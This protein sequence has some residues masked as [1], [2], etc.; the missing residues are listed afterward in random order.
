MRQ[1]VNYVVGRRN[2]DVTVKFELGCQGLQIHVPRNAVKRVMRHLVHNALDAM[3]EMSPACL[4]IRTVQTSHDWVE[5]QVND[6]G[7]GLD[8]SVRQTL[9]QEPKSTKEGDRR[10]YG[11]LFVRSVVEDMDGQ[12]KAIPS[13]SGQGTTFCFTLPV[14][15]QEENGNDDVRND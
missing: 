1:W 3:V 12:L 2:P 11:L 8:D 14:N 15:G 13:E 9:F 6:N 10:G 7:P 5:I 4:V